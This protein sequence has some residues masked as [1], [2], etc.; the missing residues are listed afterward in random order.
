M[1]TRGVDPAASPEDSDARRE[2]LVIVDI[3]LRAISVRSAKVLC[4]PSGGPSPSH[5]RISTAVAGR[6]VTRATTDA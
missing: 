3:V 1:G 6:P 5:R 2:I 4:P